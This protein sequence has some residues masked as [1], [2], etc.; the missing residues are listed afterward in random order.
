HSP[1]PAELY[2]LSL[3]TLFRSPIAT[4]KPC[5]A[6]SRVLPSRVDFTRTPVTPASSPS[7][8]STV[9]C[10]T[11]SI[12]PAST[13]ANSLSC[14][15]FSAR[16]VSRRWTRHTLRALLGRYSASST[17]VLPP[18]TTTSSCS[19]SQNPSQVAKSNTP[20]PLN[21]PSDAMPRYL[22]VAPVEM[23]SASQV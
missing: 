19:W 6:I 12:L 4:K 21:L 15:L 20:R 3:T 5:T 23:I 17:A 10:Q 8:S 2:T 13:L 18:P 14:M 22:A 16:R 7:T 1:A 11:G 9:W